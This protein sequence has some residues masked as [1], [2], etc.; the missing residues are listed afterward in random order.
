M[1][2][3][4]GSC[5]LDTS[6]LAIADELIEVDETSLVPINC[7]IAATEGVGGASEA[8]INVV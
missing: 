3:G 5:R 1:L 2:K 6:S 8:R 7:F 4:I